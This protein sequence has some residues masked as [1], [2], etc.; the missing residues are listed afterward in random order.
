MKR[1]SNYRLGAPRTPEA[2]AGSGARTAAVKI[3]ADAGMAVLAAGVLLG[4]FFLSKLILGR[5]HGSETFRLHTVMV[6]GNEK[7]S[8]DDV[9]EMGRIEKGRSIF[10]IAPADVEELVEREAWIKSAKVEKVWPDALHVT[11]REREI[12]AVALV[13][14][15]LYRV[16]RDGEMFERH[17]EGRELDKVLITGF[18]ED[19]VVH[20]SDLVEEEIRRVLQF[21]DRYEKKGLRMYA[22]IGEVHRESGGGLTVFTKTEAR[23]I[24]FGRERYLRKIRNLAVLLRHLSKHDRK[25]DY[26]LMDSEAFPDRMVVR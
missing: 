16:D 14:G 12:S 7:F 21:V 19:L 26:I 22:A 13:S 25:W 2:V 4:F 3:A 8:R 15:V 9:M 11:V 24:R 23:E 6:E 17:P 18:D 10:D 20:G 5:I 1:K